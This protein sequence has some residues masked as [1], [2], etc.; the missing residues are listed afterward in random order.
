MRFRQ[1]G[2]ILIKEFSEL[3]D[4]FVVLMIIA[5]AVGTYYHLRRRLRSQ[6]LVKRR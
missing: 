1:G 6:V 3:P 4:T 2:V 5:S